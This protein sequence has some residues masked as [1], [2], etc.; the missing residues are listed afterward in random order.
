MAS[1][2]IPNDAAFVRSMLDGVS[3][4]LCVDLARVYLVGLSNGGHFASELVCDLGDRVAAVATVGG[5]LAVDGCDPARPIPLIT[6]HGT[7]DTF[8]PFDGGEGTGIDTLNP[9]DELYDVLA[10]AYEG[11]DLAP[12]PDTVAAWAARNGCDGEPEVTEVSDEVELRAWDCDAPVHLYVVDGG[13]GT[14]PGSELF[15]AVEAT[16]GYTTMD[17]DANELIWQFFAAA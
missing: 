2:N 8:V 1:P 17:V 4:S 10:S 16:S 12:I 15:Q 13:G 5:V 6:F 9:P 3:A 11:A 14:W 7:A